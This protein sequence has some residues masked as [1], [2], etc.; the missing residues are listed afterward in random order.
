[1]I[2][3]SLFGMYRLIGHTQNI[4]VANED[5][6]IAAKQ[7]SQEVLGTCYEEVGQTY[8]YINRNGE[9]FTFEL[10]NHRLVKTPGFE[11]ML[12]D[13]DDLSFEIENDFIYMSISRD[14][15]DYRFMLTYVK[16]KQEIDDEIIEQ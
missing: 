8:E 2:V 16:E 11:I 4:T 5:I 12:T 7:V 15:K 1:M 13:I 14:K 6:Y 9:T 10:D 3:S